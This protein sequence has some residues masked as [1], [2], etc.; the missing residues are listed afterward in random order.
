M[1]K[2]IYDVAVSLDGYIAGPNGSIDGFI[3]EG[4]HA[5]DYFARLQS[6][7]TAIMGR[8]TYEFAYRFGMKAGQR[9]YP[10]MD[11]FIYSAGIELGNGEGLTIVRSDFARHLCTL[12]ASDGGDIYLCGG[13][14]FAGLLLE[15]GLI[16]RLILKVNPFIQGQ[17]T[18]LFVTDRK[19]TG[20]KKVDQNNYESG[21]TLL[22]YDF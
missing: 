15:E 12:K 13:G 20:L 4:Q 22:V 6:Y 10:H 21:V 17:G 2:I 11:H 7:S 14:R 5:Q 18:P 1:R 16:D 9:P 19:V 8:H 3:M